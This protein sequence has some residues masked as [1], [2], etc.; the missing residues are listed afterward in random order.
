MST[1]V[2]KRFVCSVCGAQYL[3]TKP[4]EVPTCC[5]KQLQPK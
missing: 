1:K 3:I 5:E 2:G 4:G